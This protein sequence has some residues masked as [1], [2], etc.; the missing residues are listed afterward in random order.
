MNNHPWYAVQVR[1]QQ[2]N[3]ASQS[4]RG[5]GFEEFLPTYKMKRRWADR[6]KVLSL[7]LFS[8][9]VFCRFTPDQ[10]S[11]VLAAAGCVQV[12]KFGS[13]LAPVPDEDI[14]TLRRLVE[15]GE[16]YPSPYVNEGMRVRVLAGAFKDVEGYIQR[17]KNQTQLIL[18]LH[19][20]QRSVSVHIDTDAVQVLQ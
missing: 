9:Y 3:I 17:V 15:T 13:T 8:G 1:A 10:K 19:L 11:L 4:L 12:V 20:L 16:A 5:R 2:E 18:S 6:M 7:P 14:E